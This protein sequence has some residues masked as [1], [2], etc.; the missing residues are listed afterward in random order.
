MAAFP[1]LGKENMAALAAIRGD[2]P[3]DGNDAREEDFLIDSMPEARDLD[4][5]MNDDVWEDIAEEESIAHAIQGLVDVQY[6]ILPFC[7]LTR[8]S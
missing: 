6:V 3:E 4:P 8:C 5:E 7:G 2:N 1:G